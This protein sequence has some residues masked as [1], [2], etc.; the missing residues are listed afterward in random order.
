M[1]KTVAASMCIGPEEDMHGVSVEECAARMAKGGA[2]VVGVNCHFD[3][4]VSLR[5]HEE[6][7]GRS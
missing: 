7:E 3:L 6:D 5:S 2:Q 4:F 1:G